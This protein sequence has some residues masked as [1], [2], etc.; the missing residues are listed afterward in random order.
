MVSATSSGVRKG[1]SSGFK[2]VPA[3]PA[4]ISTSPALHLVAAPAGNAAKIL[5]CLNRE[6]RA[7]EGA[8]DLRMDLF[9]NTHTFSSVILVVSRAAFAGEQSLLY[10]LQPSR[11]GIVSPFILLDS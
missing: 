5:G 11:A 10:T 3:S 8:D 1:K 6:L 2:R 9:L 4:V 7:G